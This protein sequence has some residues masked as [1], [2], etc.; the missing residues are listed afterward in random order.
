M[1]SRPQNCAS[2]S[3]SRRSILATL[4]GVVAAGLAGCS[5]D[6][7]GTAT[8]AQDGGD[9]TET[10][11]QGGGGTT[12]TPTP[13]GE[14]GDLNGLD[15]PGEVVHN[16]IDTAEVRTHRAAPATST[17]MNI[18]VTIQN[19]GE[20]PLSAE[21]MGGAENPLYVRARTLT[22]DGNQ[23]QIRRISS[24]PDQINPG[25]E[26][27]LISSSP[28]DRSQVGNYELCL[29]P[30]DPLLQSATTDWEDVCGE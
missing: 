1:I 20:Q 13:S 17:E 19:S 24:G 3:S 30:Q 6:G 28:F 15:I 27:T 25:T 18:E 29:V 5:G 14:N 4:G 12:E 21:P 16:D 26:A 7:G 8:P 2:K 23:L 22:G 10:P 11:S 9:S